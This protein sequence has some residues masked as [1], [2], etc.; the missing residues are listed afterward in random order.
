MKR[1]IVTGGAG[2]IGS[3]IVELFL[4]KGC[5]VTILD[6]FSTGCRENL[7]EGAKV[8]ELDICSPDVQQLLA[9]LRP[10]VLVHTAA[11]ISVSASMREPGYDAEVNI[12]G[13]INLLSGLDEQRPQVIFTS[14]GGAIYGEQEYFPADENHPIAPTSAYGLSKRVG[15]LYLDLWRR[16]FGLSACVLRLANVYG[17]RQNP[18]GEAGV[19]AI[20][21]KKLL[22]GDRPTLYGSGEQTRDFVYVE[23]VAAAAWKAAE[24]GTSGT[25]NIGTG[26]ETDV[27][28][29]FRIISEE[30]GSELQPI[31]EPRRPGE[32]LRSCIDSQLASQV[33]NWKAETDI[34][35]GLQKTCMWFRKHKAC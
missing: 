26:I 27:N 13:L 18:H 5:E 29:L 12:C 1:V 11:Q 2:F 10:E 21:N 9:E 23:D 35:A 25:F 31:R 24:Q 34:C 15:E 16:E 22:T 32:Q 3:H 28:T 8:H 4:S 14:T 33:L 20:F 19:V 7:P 17:P 30:L 6:N